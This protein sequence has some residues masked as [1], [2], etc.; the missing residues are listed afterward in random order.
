MSAIREE[1]KQNVSAF[2]SEFWAGVVKPYYNPEDGDDYWMGFVEKT[3]KIAEQY[4]KYDKRIVEIV[5]GFIKGVEKVYKE[6]TN[7]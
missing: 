4:G 5:L 6:K 2:M 3:M 1:Q 7:G